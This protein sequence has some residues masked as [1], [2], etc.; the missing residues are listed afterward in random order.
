MFIK[1]IMY[2]HENS[3]SNTEQQW[4]SKPNR[5]LQCCV[6]DAWNVSVLCRCGEL[7]HAYLQ[8]SSPE[9][10]LLVGGDMRKIHLCF[11]ILKVWASSSVFLYSSQTPLENSSIVTCLCMLV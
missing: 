1:H 9:A 3:E 8:D 6:H 2:L 10:R 7:V 5:I 4:E 11:Q